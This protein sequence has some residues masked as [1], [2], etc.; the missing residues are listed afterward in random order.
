MNSCCACLVLTADR[1]RGIVE[2][3]V[4]AGHLRIPSQ[5][6]GEEGGEGRGKGSEERG[7]A[8]MAGKGR[9]RKVWRS[10]ERRAKERKKLSISSG[11][12]CLSGCRM[13]KMDAWWRDVQSCEL[14]QFQVENFEYTS[15]RSDGVDLFTDMFWSDMM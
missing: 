12:E 7:I 4:G 3:S 5:A 1:A 9:G 13:L 11:D 2:K 6:R 15:D 14:E 10:G 8:G